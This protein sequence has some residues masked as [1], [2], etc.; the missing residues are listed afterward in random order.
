MVRDC[1]K[2]ILDWRTYIDDGEGVLALYESRGRTRRLFNRAPVLR[3]RIESFPV[4]K[5]IVHDNLAIYD[6]FLPTN[7]VYPEFP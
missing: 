6:R 5:S 4:Q 3:I 2:D 7:F 1:G